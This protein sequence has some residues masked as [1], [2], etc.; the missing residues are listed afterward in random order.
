[1]ARSVRLWSDCV[2]RRR[3][4][5]VGRVRG[6][7]SNPIIQRRLVLKLCITII[8][9]S[10]LHLLIPGAR[11]MHSTTLISRGTHSIDTSVSCGRHEPP[12]PQ[13]D[14]FPKALPPPRALLSLQ[15]RLNGKRDFAHM[16]AIVD[17]P[18]P[19]QIDRDTLDRKQTTHNTTPQRLAH[20]L[21]PQQRPTPHR[22]NA[23]RRLS[24]L[25]ILC[26]RRGPSACYVRNPPSHHR[27]HNSILLEPIPLYINGRS[28]SL[29]TH[30]NFAGLR[31]SDQLYHNPLSSCPRAGLLSARP[32]MRSRLSRPMLSHSFATRTLETPA[33]RHP[34][35]PVRSSAQACSLSSI[36]SIRTPQNENKTKATESTACSMPCDL[37]GE[38]L[39]FAPGLNPWA[40][41]CNL[42]SP[43]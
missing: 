41:V 5:P 21:V 36:R 28:K 11:S 3:L 19:H 24:L 23:R 13:L 38:Y 25:S 43:V 2:C 9:S 37:R 12:T 16:R 10:F 31:L 15:L 4:A 18:G 30:Q 42:P 14:S 17:A 1:M 26:G 20:E 29:K 8:S 33:T 27:R 34:R 6:C 32:L 22:P 35:H 7:P 40:A 39:S